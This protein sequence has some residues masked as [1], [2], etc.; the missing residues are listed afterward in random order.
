MRTA[1][2]RSSSRRSEFVSQRAHVP[3][4]VLP[5]TIG[6]SPGAKD[7]YSLYDDTLTRLLGALGK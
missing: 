7:L 5:Y 6:G 1:A 4:V 2:R 3:A